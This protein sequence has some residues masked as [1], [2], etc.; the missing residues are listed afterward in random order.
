MAP[1]LGAS[2]LEAL[3]EVILGRFD[4][5]SRDSTDPAQRDIMIENLFNATLSVGATGSSSSYIKRIGELVLDLDSSV[6]EW[7]RKEMR[8]AH[9]DE[10]AKGSP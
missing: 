4:E 10:Y 8:R 7:A 6:G 1:I 2:H 9:W 3:L 5:L